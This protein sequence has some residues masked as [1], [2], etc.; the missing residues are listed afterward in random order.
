M[1]SSCHLVAASTQNA[2]QSGTWHKTQSAQPFSQHLTKGSQ[3][4]V[5]ELSWRRFSL[6][7]L[8]HFPMESFMLANGVL[9]RCSFLHSPNPR[10]TKK[11]FFSST[12]PGV[13][14]R[15]FSGLT[16]PW[17]YLRKSK[18]GLGNCLQ[19]D[20]YLEDAGVCRKDKKAS[21]LFCLLQE[22]AAKENL[23]CCPFPDTFQALDCGTDHPS[24]QST[25]P[26]Q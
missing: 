18:H 1:Y 14:I 4:A 12:V 17:T 10:S 26:L 13:P 9:L 2:K 19:T 3:M 6:H 20:E 5:S 7:K 21:N 24:S 23:I 8:M 16:S 11:S 22:R 25:Y 15:K